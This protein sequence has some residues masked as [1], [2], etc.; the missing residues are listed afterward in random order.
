M[1]SEAPSVDHRVLS[2]LVD[3]HHHLWDLDAGSYPWLQGPPQDSTDPS[4]LGQLQHDYL[5]DDFLDDADGL[6]LVA[7]VHVEAARAPDE[8]ILETRWLQEVTDASE[9]PQALVVGARLQ[10]AGVEALLEAHLDNPCVRG[11]RQ[12]LNWDPEHRVAERPD[13]LSD[14]NWLAGLRILKRF[15]LSFDLQVFPHQLEEA[16]AVVR[17]NPEIVFILNHGGFLLPDEPERRAQWRS[18][19][20]TL[21]REPNI[22]VKVSSY[23]SLDPQIPLGGLRRFLLELLDTFGVERTMFASNFPVDKRFISY[24]DMVQTY[25]EATGE[26]DDHERDQFFCAN[27]LR[28]YR[29]ANPLARS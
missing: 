26:L 27:A 9:F 23:A 6:P 13:L 12:M 2:R 3:A 16:A 11:V 14:V 7:S 25:I 1:Q 19:I 15:D 4:T 24:V 5:V 29:I 21:A 8:A 17:S 20:A 22:A 18:G 28:Y 10:S